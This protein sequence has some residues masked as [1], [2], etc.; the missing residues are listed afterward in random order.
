MNT[1]SGTRKG[2]GARVRVR[3]VRG[4]GIEPGTSTPCQL[5]GKSRLPAVSSA[6]R[7]SPLRATAH[8]GDSLKQSTR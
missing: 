3:S 2:S 5:T 6:K 4:T 8:G 7:S 1:W